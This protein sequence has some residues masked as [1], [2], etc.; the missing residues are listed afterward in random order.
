MHY[1]LSEREMQ[2]ILLGAQG[3]EDKAIADKMGV[4][5]NSVRTYW[6]RARQKTGTCN[7]T[8]CVIVV[9]NASGF[10]SDLLGTM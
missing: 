3:F 8:Q 4:A 2:T 7:R 1:G 10:V 5:V 6:E 9:L